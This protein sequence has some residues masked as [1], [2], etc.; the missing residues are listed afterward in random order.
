M[1]WLLAAQA[2]FLRR[3][4]PSLEEYL[5]FTADEDAANASALAPL[6]GVPS[7]VLANGTDGPPAAHA[8]P[9]IKCPAGVTAN[10][11]QLQWRMANQRRAY[12]SG[13]PQPKETFLF[14]I[15]PPG[16]GS[17][18]IMSLIATSPMVGTLCTAGS[19]NCEGCWLLYSQGLMAHKRRWERD[20]PADWTK[21]IKL[22]QQFWP[23]GKPIKLEKSPNNVVKT[24]QIVDDLT[25]AGKHVRFVVLTRSPCFLTTPQLLLG[26]GVH[27]WEFFAQEM[28]ST[29]SRSPKGTGTV[30]AVHVRYEDLLADPYEVSKRLLDWLPQLG[31]L[32][33]TENPLPRLGGEMLDPSQTKD[34]AKSVVQYLLEYGH[35]PADHASVDP[36]YR[37]L[38]QKLGYPTQ[39]VTAP[40]PAQV[41]AAR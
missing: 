26:G 31:S 40:A 21:A 5:G 6:I 12:A 29:L 20:Q 1:L 23:T 30:D 3:Q 32:D 24:Q 8:V 4:V 41:V 22:F 34:R 17:T 36:K 15:S 38:M 33:P 7:P 25:S 18:A 39:A 11:A 19:V 10:K 16:Y 9:W 27:P 2:V 28:I 14:V 35:I 37:A 13:V